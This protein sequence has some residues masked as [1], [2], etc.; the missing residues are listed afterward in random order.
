MVTEDYSCNV[1][2]SAQWTWDNSTPVPFWEGFGLICLARWWV[3]VGRCLEV[4]LSLWPFPSKGISNSNGL[5]QSRQKNAVNGSC[6][7]RDRWQIIGGYE[8]R[9]KRFKFYL[10]FGDSYRLLLDCCSTG[11]RQILEGSTAHWVCP[12]KAQT[13]V[14]LWVALWRALL[15]NPL[16]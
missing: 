3:W 11:R 5:K 10:A 8:G 9:V 14:R 6:N 15:Q 1:E 16:V 4:S 12:R 7:I 2:C 13:L